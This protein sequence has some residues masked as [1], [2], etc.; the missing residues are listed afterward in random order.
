MS[1]DKEAR[2][3][4]RLRAL[5]AEQGGAEAVAKQHARGRQSVRERI[6]ALVDK[7]SFREQGGLAGAAS[8]RRLGRARRASCPRTR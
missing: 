8:T 1:W 6:D 2:E 5:A 4:E 3:I 7:G